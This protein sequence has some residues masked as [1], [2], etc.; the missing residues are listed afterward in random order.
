MAQQFC[1]NRI[2]IIRFVEQSGRQPGWFIEEI[3]AGQLGW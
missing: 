1:L 2:R 3:A